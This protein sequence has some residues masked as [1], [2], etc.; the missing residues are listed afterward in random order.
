MIDQEILDQVGKLF[1]V[2]QQAIFAIISI[3]VIGATQAFKNIYFGFHNVKKKEKRKAIIWL[4]AVSAGLGGGMIGHYTSTVPQPIW[5][6]IF[7]GIM[8][9]GASIGL[10]ALIVKK[11]MPKLFGAKDAA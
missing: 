6:W 8:S 5:F 2:Q 4:F 3:A 7:T 1:T 11:I 9:G 10:F